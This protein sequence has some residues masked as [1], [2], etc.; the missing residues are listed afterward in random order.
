MNAGS[1]KRPPGGDSHAGAEENPGPLPAA[2]HASALVIGESGVLIRGKSGAGKSSLVMAL[3]DAAS[4]RHL[5]ARLVADD[6]VQ[7][8]VAGDRLLASPH[9]AISGLIEERGAGILS[10]DFEASA[11]IACVVDLLPEMG[12]S[13]PARLPEL[14]ELTTNIG[15][16]PLRRIVLPAGM[17]SET[18][19]RRILAIF[20]DG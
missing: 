17:P 12:A 11:R 19:A 9:P 6:R 13:V 15:E 16:I 14:S 5:F 10:R 3:L 1:A 4:R 20:T 18:A 2:V 8:H 7:L